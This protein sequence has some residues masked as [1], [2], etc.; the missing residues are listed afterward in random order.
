ML[1]LLLILA[2]LGCLYW[3]YQRDYGGGGQTRPV[4]NQA[5]APNPTLAPGNRLGGGLNP[6][7]TDTDVAPPPQRPPM[8]SGVGGPPQRPPMPKIPGA[9]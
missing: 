9:R 7:V 6:F 2:V 4:A 5:A 3:I 1:R 8:D